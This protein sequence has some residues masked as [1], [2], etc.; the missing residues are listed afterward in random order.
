V[1]KRQDSGKLLAFRS[2]AKQVKTA[3]SGQPPPS[4]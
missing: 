4:N 3:D 2:G 1:Y